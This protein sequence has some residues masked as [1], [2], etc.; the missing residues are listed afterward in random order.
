M[1][2]HVSKELILYFFPPSYL[3]RII[4]LSTGKKEW[5]KHWQRTAKKETKSDK[6]EEKMVHK[7][8]TIIT[9]FA[10]VDLCLWLIYPNEI[11]ERERVINNHKSY[12][13]AGGDQTLDE[14]RILPLTMTDASILVKT[15]QGRRFCLLMAW[16]N[17]E[18]ATESLLEKPSAVLLIRTEESPYTGAASGAEKGFTTSVVDRDDAKTR[19]STVPKQPQQMWVQLSSS[20]S[21]GDPGERPA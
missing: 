3:A 1:I 15:G 12:I 19:R 21:L 11:L 14:S 13:L 8:T 17:T 2:T 6:K 16:Y 4:F 7:L 5:G 18:R 9:E 10:P 20:S